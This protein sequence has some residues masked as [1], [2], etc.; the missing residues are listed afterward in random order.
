[1]TGAHRCWFGVAAFDDPDRVLRH[2]KR[3][4]DGRQPVL[5]G[6]EQVHQPEHHRVAAEYNRVGA[7]GASGFAGRTKST[8]RQWSCTRQSVFPSPYANPGHGGDVMALPPRPNLEHLRHQARNLLRAAKAGDPDATERIRTF[9]DRVTLQAA[10]LAIAREHGW[11][12]WPSMREHV[13]QLQRINAVADSPTGLDD[14]LAQAQSLLRAA[15]DGDPQAVGQMRAVSDQLTLAV[16]QDVIARDHAGWASWA[17]LQ[18]HVER[19]RRIQ[20]APSAA[21]EPPSAA[22]LLGWCEQAA[23]RWSSFP[24]DAVPRPI[25]LTGRGV[26]LGDRAGNFKFLDGASKQAFVSGMIHGATG[27]PDEPVELLRRLGRAHLN[28]PETATSLLLTRAERSEAEFWTDRG[29][30]VLSAWRIETSGARGAIWALDV[31]ALSRCWCPPAPDPTDPRPPPQDLMHDLGI[32]RATLFGDAM[33]L[34]LRF[35]AK[36]E[37]MA[38]YQALVV[39]TPTALCIAPVEQQT[40]STEA[41]ATWHHASR[42]LTARLTLPL[43]ARVVVNLGGNPVT[44]LSWEAT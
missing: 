32:D 14:L 18:R 16:A 37:S 17:A 39:E 30:R 7:G 2:V 1:M 8:P 34:R 3:G 5:P 44:V 19:L 13:E 35:K 9:S 43:D 23:A 10:Q 28:R 15:Q 38:T 24:V 4:P 12:S 41:G 29:R 25:V 26:R 42:E 40:R 11:V 36:A 33:T 31:D 6:L 20:Q 27:V 21:I 22:V